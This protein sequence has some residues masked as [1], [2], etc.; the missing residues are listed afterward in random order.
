MSNYDRFPAVKV[1]NISGT[2]QQGYDD[3]L[4]VLKSHINRPDFILAADTYPGVRDEEIL[5]QLRKLNPDLL[6]SMFASFD[7]VALDQACADACNASPEIPGSHLAKSDHSHHDVFT[8]VHPETNWKT[9]LAHAE[10][11]GLG[12]REYELIRI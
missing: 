4:A 1:Q 7:P 6:I 8:D 5:P 10:E 2:L 9:C 3:I 12:K 11:I